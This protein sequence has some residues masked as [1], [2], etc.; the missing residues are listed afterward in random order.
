MASLDEDWKLPAA[1][2][3]KPHDYAYDLDRALSSVVGLSAQVPA[4]AFTAEILGTDRAGN[5][6]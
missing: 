4:D 6:V 3:H 2:Q 1:V 5:G